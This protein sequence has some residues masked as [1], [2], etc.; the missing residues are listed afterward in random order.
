MLTLLLQGG[1]ANYSVIDYAGLLRYRANKVKEG[2]STYCSM[3]AVFPEQY[4][5][6]CYPILK[7]RSVL[8][9]FN[10]LLL[11]EGDLSAYT[12]TMRPP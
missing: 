7:C 10:V 9:A 4:T 5:S 1:E 11:D 6:N 8:T 3:P 2:K 12:Q